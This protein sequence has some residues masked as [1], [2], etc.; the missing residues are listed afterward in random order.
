[1]TSQLGQTAKVTRM[2]FYGGLAAIVIYIVGSQILGLALAYLDSIRPQKEIPATVGFGKLPPPNFRSYKLSGGFPA[3]ELDNTTGDLPAMPAKLE[4]Y[5]VIEPKSSYLSLDRAKDLS[6]RLGFTAAPQ[7]LST[8]IYYWEEDNK[9]LKMNVYTQNFVMDSDLSKLVIP[10]G[11]LPLASNISNLAKT[12]LS[13]K[14]IL[15][16]GYESGTVKY[17]LATVDNGQ[18]VKVA[19]PA[20]ASLALINFYRTL[21]DPEDKRDTDYPPLLPPDP[22]QGNIKVMAY[23][24]KNNLEP[25]RIAYNNWVIDKENAETYPLKNIGAAWQEVTGGTAV[26]ASLTNKATTTPEP[27]SGVMLSKVF[28]RNIYLA[29]FDDED[30]QKYLQPIY[31]FEGE[32]RDGDGNAYNIT[33]YT[34]AINPAWVEQ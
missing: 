15:T 32:G 6:K 18:I 13:E 29:Y 2:I 26:I 34:H 27:A 31:V 14:G 7:N 17:D 9:T 10:V 4:V 23:S 5:P 16:N 19:S 12:I 25:V 21:K 11:E 1:M 24:P 30:L 3:V 20:D 33:F 22:S 8:S 28:I